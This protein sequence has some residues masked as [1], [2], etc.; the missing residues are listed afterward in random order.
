M[1][2]YGISFGLTFPMKKSKTTID[3]GIEAGSRGTTQAGL[4]KENFINFN[5]GVSISESWFHKRKYR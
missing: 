5:F 4:I 1:N 2:E 3:L